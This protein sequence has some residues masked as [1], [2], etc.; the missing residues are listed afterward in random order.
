MWWTF[1]NICDHTFDHVPGDFQLLFDY[2]F[3]SCL[4]GILLSL[5]ILVWV[6]GLAELLKIWEANVAILLPI[7]MDI[8]STFTPPHGGPFWAIHG[9]RMHSH[10][11]RW[12]RAGGWRLSSWCRWVRG[13]LG[14]ESRCLGRT[15]RAGISSACN[16][17]LCGEAW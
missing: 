7:L 3:S 13:Y 6:L 4:H 8:A 5:L 15:A 12:H 14:E 16:G 9:S 10:V 11:W 17:G 1:N 2:I